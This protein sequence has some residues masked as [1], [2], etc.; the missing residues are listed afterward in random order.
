MNWADDIT[1]PVPG[2][3][4]VLGTILASKYTYIFIAILLVMWFLRGL[5]NAIPKGLLVIAVIFIGV[6]AGVVSVNLRK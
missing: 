1:V 6:I 4:G 3:G 2:L 5:W